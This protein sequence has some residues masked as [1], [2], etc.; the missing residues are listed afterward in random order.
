MRDALACAR[1]AFK[2]KSFRPP[3]EG[4][5]LSLAWP[6][7]SNQRE[8]HPMARPPGILPCGCAGGLRGFSTAHPCA[9]EKLAGIHAGHP[10]GFPPPTRRAIGAP[11]RAARSRRALFREAKSKARQQQS[12]ASPLPLPLPLPLLLL[13]LVSFSALHR[14][15]ARTARCFTRGPCAAVRRG[16]QAAQRAS[17]WMDSPFRTG[18]MPVRKARPRLTDLPGRSPASAKWG[19]LSLWLLSL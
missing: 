10:A 14:V 6:R 12:R 13:L 5:L 17:P 11:G 1:G 15:R 9:G 7:E 8:G 19:G 4:E 2:I 16:R 3:S 18:R